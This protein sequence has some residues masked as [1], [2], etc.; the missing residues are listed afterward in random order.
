VGLVYPIAIEHW[1]S[2]FGSVRYALSSKQIRRKYCQ[3][4]AITGN[5]AE[6]TQSRSRE[7][8]AAQNQLRIPADMINPRRVGQRRSLA[9]ARRQ[10]LPSFVLRRGTLDCLPEWLGSILTDSYR[11]SQ[12]YR[13]QQR[14]KHS[15]TVNLASFV[16]PSLIPHPEGRMSMRQPAVALNCNLLLNSLG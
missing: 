11:R 15:T 14:P 9:P 3:Y 6:I 16:Q 4:L 13:N 5:V 12:T 7:L 2:G 8:I 1:K 10:R